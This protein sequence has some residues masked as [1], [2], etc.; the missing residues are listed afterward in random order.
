MGVK[1]EVELYRRSQ[2][3]VDRRGHGLTMGALYWQL[4][5]IWQAPTW[6]SIGSC[7]YC[8]YIIDQYSKT[9]L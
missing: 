8:V 9:S 5:D 3:V 6:S 2:S 4:N 7:L 1:T